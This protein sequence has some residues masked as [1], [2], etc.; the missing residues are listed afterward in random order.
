MPPSFILGSSSRYCVFLQGSRQRRRRDRAHAEG[1]E[2]FGQPCK[3]WRTG[4]DSLSDNGKRRLLRDL[5]G[6]RARGAKVE[7]DFVAYLADQ[8]REAS[9][10]EL[11]GA[12]VAKLAAD[13][14][15]YRALG[16]SL[17]VPVMNWIGRR[18]EAV[19]KFKKKTAA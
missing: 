10:R 19:A 8:F 12:E 9:G 7:D 5:A 4:R 15:R 18:I 16:N 11:T 6:E 14:P 17:A 1:H 3:C 2:P 13:G